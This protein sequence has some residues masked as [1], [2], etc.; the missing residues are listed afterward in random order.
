MTIF[1]RVG[2]QKLPPYQ[3]VTQYSRGLQ[4]TEND[5]V[6][7]SYTKDS[8]FKRCSISAAILVRLT[9]RASAILKSISRLGNLLLLSNMLT[10]CGA[11]PSFSPSSAWVQLRSRRNFRRTGPKA[12][13][14]F[15]N[16]HIDNRLPIAYVRSIG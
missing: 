13:I 5:N 1:D 3:F 10:C 11:T 6:C 16:M 15:W 8:H 9:P 14:F 2:T 7:F 4:H 12:K